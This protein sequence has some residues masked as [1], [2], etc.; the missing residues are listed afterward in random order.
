MLGT[1]GVEALLA[2]ASLFGWL[3]HEAETE[4]RGLLHLEAAQALMPPP[5]GPDVEEEGP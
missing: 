4:A 2:E 3:L 1:S 5:Q